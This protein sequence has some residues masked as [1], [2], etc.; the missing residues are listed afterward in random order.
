MEGEVYR[1]ELS[2]SMA[3]GRNTATH[4]D[5]VALEGEIGFGDELYLLRNRARR[6]NI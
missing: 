4:T 5:P 1:W 3:T 6:K 2:S